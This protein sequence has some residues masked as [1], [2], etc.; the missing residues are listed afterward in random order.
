MRAVPWAT[1]LWPGLAKLWYQ[2]DGWALAVSVLFAAVVNLLLV[3]TFLWPHWLPA[4][5]AWIGW[6]LVALTWTTSAIHTLRHLKDFQRPI[7]QVDVGLFI[8]AQH[9]YLRGH[10][11]EAETILQ[12]LLAESRN[13]VPS[14]LLLATLYRRTRR[15]DEASRQ[16]L[17]IEQLDAAFY[18]SF[19]ITQERRRL[20]RGLSVAEV[21]PQ[22]GAAAEQKTPGGQQENEP[23]ASRVT[24]SPDGTTATDAHRRADHARTTPQ[25]VSPDMEASA[26]MTD[27]I[28]APS[29]RLG[30]NETQ[31]VE[32]VNDPAVAPARSK[33]T[34]APQT[35]SRRARPKNKP[36]EAIH[37]QK[38]EVPHEASEPSL[39]DAVPNALRSVVNTASDHELTRP[40]PVHSVPVP[41]AR[42]DSNGRQQ[43]AYFSAFGAID[44]ERSGKVPAEEVPVL[45]TPTS[46]VASQVPSQRRAANKSEKVFKKRTVAEATTTAKIPPGT[47]APPP[48][49]AMPTLDKLTATENDSAS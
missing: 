37:E 30:A 10:W 14:L 34:A 45:S 46:Q 25:P 17:R 41:M 5:L 43:D 22:S 11:F 35:E 38:K 24:R 31:P 6:P 29:E 47:A 33:Q 48:D 32:P 16:L 13:D 9:E 44:D 26:T 39:T 19:E 20:E 23:A 18:W 7:P 8:Q 21:E 15:F 2:G 27:P 49:N 4:L 40:D 12:R 3:S 36:A 42:L 1:C 28:A